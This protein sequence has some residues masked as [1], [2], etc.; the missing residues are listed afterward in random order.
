MNFNKLKLLNLSIHVA[1]I[2]SSVHELKGGW[3]SVTTMLVATWLY[4]FIG[5]TYRPCGHPGPTWGD[6]A[7]TNLLSMWH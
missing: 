4:K 2:N 3:V 7:S 5:E 6:H 1:D